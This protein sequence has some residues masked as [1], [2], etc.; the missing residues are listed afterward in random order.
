[1]EVYCWSGSSWEWSLNILIFQ[2]NDYFWTLF[3]QKATKKLNYWLNSK[4]NG[5]IL[6]SKKPWAPQRKGWEVRGSMGHREL[7]FSPSSVFSAS[8]L[9]WTSS[10]L[11]SGLQN[12]CINLDMIFTHASVQWKLI[13]IFL[14]SISFV[15]RDLFSQLI[16][17]YVTR[18]FQ[19]SICK[20]SGNW[21]D[22]AVAVEKDRVPESRCCSLRKEGRGG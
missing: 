15:R 12:G 2:E 19:H 8:L 5:V 13:N 10:W 11:P 7:A 18:T 21:F 14:L 22:E 3:F 1:M 20:G 17:S 6:Y 16:L 9:R 4:E